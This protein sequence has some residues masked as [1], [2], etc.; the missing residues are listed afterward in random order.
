MTR[1]FE[2]ELGQLKRDVLVMGGLVEAAVERAVHAFVNGDPQGARTVI[3][4]DAEVDALELRIEEECLKLLA[5]YGPTAR[6]LRLV[7]GAFKITN[8]LERVGDLAVNVSER[9]LDTDAGD[10]RYGV[11]EIEEMAGRVRT[12]LRDALDSFVSSDAARARAVL[13]MDDRVDALLRAIYDHQQEAMRGN[14]ACFPAALRILSTAKYLERIADH[15]T[16]VA[17]DVIYMVD[18][19]VVRHRN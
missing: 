7:V 14:P 16:N 6:D 1:H 8:D 4:G 2:H 12:M 18:G 9:A 15:A 5:L 19:T 3:N 11:D 10:R 17:E 13:G